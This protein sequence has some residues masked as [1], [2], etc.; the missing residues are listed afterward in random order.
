MTIMCGQ[1]APAVFD[2]LTRHNFRWRAESVHFTEYAVNA[3]GETL[4]RLPAPD[5]LIEWRP[6]ADLPPRT[7]GTSPLSI[8]VRGVRPKCPPRPN[9]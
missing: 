8:V 4:T 5:D 6:I 7:S 9:E 3:T 2:G 1:L